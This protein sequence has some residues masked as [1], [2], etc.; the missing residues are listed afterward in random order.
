M[1]KKKKRAIWCLGIG[2]RSS[3]LKL[4]DE[5]VRKLEVELEP[6]VRQGWSSGAMSPEESANAELLFGCPAV[7]THVAF[8]QGWF[9]GGLTICPE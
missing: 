3:V 6:H 7:T 2:E 5:Q 9:R 8:N 4:L 1:G